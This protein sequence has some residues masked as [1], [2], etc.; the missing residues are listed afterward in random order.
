MRAGYGY[1][2]STY[3]PR[4]RGGRWRKRRRIDYGRG[5]TAAP[6][7]AGERPSYSVHGVGSG[8][9]FGTSGPYAGTGHPCPTFLSCFFWRVQPDLAALVQ[10]WLI[11]RLIDGHRPLCRPLFHTPYS[12]S[13]PKT[14][15]T[16]KTIDID[17]KTVVPSSPV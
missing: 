9:R 3:A 10:P 11:Q 16:I 7:D 8:F 14:I 5:A 12:P 2:R 13:T 17:I 15:K 4:G 6:A 1:I